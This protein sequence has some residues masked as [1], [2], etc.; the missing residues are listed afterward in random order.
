M[1]SLGKTIRQLR[2]SKGTTQEQ[3]AARL[4][5]SCQAIS[6]WENEAALPDILLLPHLADYF[7]VSIDE[8]FGYKLKAYT[9]KERFI[10][11]L[12]DSGV[13]AVS[14][15]TYSI[16][17]ER[18]SNNSQIAQIG[19]FFA[20]FIQESNL[21]FDAIMGMAYHGIAF[22]AATAFAL[23][24][25]YGVVTAYCHDRQAADSRGRFI[26]GYTPQDGDKI[27]VIDDLI[28]SGQTLSKR[29]DK[30]YALAKVDI[31][32]VITLADI[33]ALTSD[34]MCGSAYIA[35]KYRTQVYSIITDGD[36][37]NAIQKRI[38]ILEH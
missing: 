21:T 26:C 15:D 30:L 34:T 32:A 18:I 6:K 16:N 4:H 19:S 29:L 2:Q 17:T 14:A 22:S 37:Q 36:I 24:Q 25:K 5:V 3:L 8:L 23:H 20:D 31:A 9:Y 1:M 38:L 11:F 28:S 12:Y 13:M 7:G 10:K 27:V 35:E 33:K